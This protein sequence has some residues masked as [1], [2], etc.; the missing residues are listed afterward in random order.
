MTTSKAVDPVTLHAFVEAAQK[1]INAEQEKNF[2]SLPRTLLSIEIGRRYARI[3][4]S[5]GSFD[6]SVYCF[7]DLVNGDVLKAASWKAPAKH[8]RGSVHDENLT[9][10]LTAY[11]AQ[12]LR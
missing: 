5:S 1:V 10:G 6:R 3:V 7:V 8:A 9:S 12:Y 2:P 4:K 11:G